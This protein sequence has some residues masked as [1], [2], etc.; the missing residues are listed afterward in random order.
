MRNINTHTGYKIHYPVKH[1]Y[2][3]RI[4]TVLS[5]K[6]QTEKIIQDVFDIIPLC[7]LKKE[8]YPNKLDWSNE[9]IS[10]IINHSPSD[11]EKRKEEWKWIFYMNPC[12][13]QT[14]YTIN[15]IKER[16]P[17]LA[18]YINLWIEFL[19]FE[20]SSDIS[21]HTFIH[22]KVPSLNPIII[23]YAHNNDV[24]IYEWKYKNNTDS[25]RQLDVISIPWSKFDENDN[26][27]Q[28]AKK[29]DNIPDFL[30]NNIES[31]LKSR[32]DKLCKDNGETNKFESRKQTNGDYP[33]Y[34]LENGKDG[35]GNTVWMKIKME[36]SKLPKFFMENWEDDNW[37]TIWAEL[38][39]ENE[40]T[41]KISIKNE[42]WLSIPIT[43]KN[44][45]IP[46]LISYFG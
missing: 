5:R 4:D 14:L 11:I 26:I 8:Y 29:S 35:S 3:S 17:D 7:F 27:I 20:E 41:P 18:Q 28:I 1:N 24:Y 43:F 23:D 40:R 46:Y 32:T 6:N 22:I 16:F 45:N 25:I 38:I 34:C 33:I 19:Q 13:S 44:E 36:N 31:K 2:T 30:I 10:N 39:I 12:I 42:D 9:E 15:K 37:N 21:A